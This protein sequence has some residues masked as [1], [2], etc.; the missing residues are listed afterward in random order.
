MEF[1]RC[2]RK[3]SNKRFNYCPVCAAKH[4]RKLDRPE[5]NQ[6]I[7][8]IKELKSYTKVGEKYNVSDNSVKKWFI[9]YGL[10]EHIKELKEHT[11]NIQ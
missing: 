10:P 3:I 7:S 6:L 11:N 2:G 8:D 5:L 9:S 1:R 4:K